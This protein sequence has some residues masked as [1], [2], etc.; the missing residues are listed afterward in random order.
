MTLLWILDSH[1]GFL[2]PWPLPDEKLLLLLSSSTLVIV[3]MHK[4]LGAWL[5]WLA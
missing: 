3:S 5:K 4:Y 1:S 2:L